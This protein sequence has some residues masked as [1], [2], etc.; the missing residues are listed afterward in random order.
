MYV[1]N[2]KQIFKGHITLMFVLVSFFSCFLLKLQFL[3]LFFLLFSF[4]NFDFTIYFY[5]L[6]L[7]SVLGNKLGKFTIYQIEKTAFTTEFLT[8]A[9]TLLFSLVMTLIVVGV[10]CL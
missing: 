8:V 5:I 4:S 9:S 10:L 7:N 1:Q 6:G 3:C 2:S